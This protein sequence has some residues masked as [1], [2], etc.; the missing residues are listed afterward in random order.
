MK[1]TIAAVLTAFAMIVALVLP[2]SAF[3]LDADLADDVYAVDYTLTGDG[4]MKMVEPAKLVVKDGKA[5]AR[6][7]WNDPEVDK[8]YLGG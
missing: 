8:L 2:M 7:A 6:P 4:T 3:A 1:K 5:Y